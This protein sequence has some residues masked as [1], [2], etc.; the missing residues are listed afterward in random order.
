MKV[1]RRSINALLRIT[2]VLIKVV[3]AL[4]K[5]DISYLYIASSVATLMEGSKFYRCTH[6]IRELEHLDINECAGAIW[7]T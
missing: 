7:T 2:D 5:R 6:R 4:S 3:G 1:L